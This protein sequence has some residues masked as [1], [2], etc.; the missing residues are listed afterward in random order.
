MFKASAHILV[1]ITFIAS[2]GIALPQPPTLKRKICQPVVSLAVIPPAQLT[3]PVVTNLDIRGKLLR[4]AD[5]MLN[6]NKGQG[7]ITDWSVQAV[8]L[9][10][11]L[12]LPEDAIRERVQERLRDFF[13]IG[14]QLGVGTKQKYKPP[15][16]FRPLSA[17]E[18]K[19]STKY[20]LREFFSLHVQSGAEDIDTTTTNL[21]FYKGSLGIAHQLA[22]LI[23][24]SE[25]L[26]T[27]VFHAIQTNSGEASR[28]AAEG[29]PKSLLNVGLMSL[30]RFFYSVGS[31]Y[32][33][34]DLDEAIE[35][36]QRVQ[37]HEKATAEELLRDLVEVVTSEVFFERVTPYVTNSRPSEVRSSIYRSALTALR[38]TGEL[39]YTYQLDSARMAYVTVVTSAESIRRIV[40]LT[41]KILAE[42]KQF[43]SD[44]LDED[45]YNEVLMTLEAANLKEKLEY[46]AEI[47]RQHNNPDMAVAFYGAARNQK[48]VEGIIHEQMQEPV[49]KLVGNQLIYYWIPALVR[50]R[51]TEFLNEV[52]LRV[53]QKN[54][55]VDNELVAAAIE[56]AQ[57]KYW[58]HQALQKDGASESQE[59][60]KR[61]AYILKSVILA[62]KNFAAF[63]VADIDSI[64]QRAQKSLAEH[65]YSQAYSDYQAILD[66]DG[67]I[68]VGDAWVKA[69]GDESSVYP[70]MAAA[71]IRKLN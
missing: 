64:R 45:L 31:P 37:G 34:Y 41:D 12:G 18:Q 40:K 25:L 44:N 48:R 10:R 16:T 59:W 53:T 11:E 21:V 24:D 3:S 23:H 58:P 36:L 61:G 27:V 55:P 6:I 4:A 38:I 63:S 68:A 56:S 29:H 14:S 26:E 9:Y 54:V 13:A 8:Y 5:G 43:D 32:R 70:Y 15:Q 2:A 67:L 35:S 19:F 17:E 30:A 7:N 49:K 57:D 69:H 66:V 51:A 28:A 20:G 52:Q 71:V 46:I 1:A 47:F 33:I 42:T 65:N 50:L 62:K 39:E 22:N 60:K